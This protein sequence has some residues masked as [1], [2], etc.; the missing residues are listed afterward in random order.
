MIFILKLFLGKLE[1]KILLS[2]NFFEILV[3]T[4]LKTLFFKLKGKKSNTSITQI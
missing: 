1:K 3:C 2:D 4:K